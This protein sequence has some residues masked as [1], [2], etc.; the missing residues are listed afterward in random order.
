[1][2]NR[3]GIIFLGLVIAFMAILVGVLAKQMMSASE[4]N[5]APYN[6]PNEL[7]ERAPVGSVVS[8]EGIATAR[9]IKGVL[10]SLTL[11]APIFLHDTLLTGK[12]SAM[13]AMLIDD[14]TLAQGE[15]SEIMIEEYLFDPEST[16][17]NN[18]TLRVVT[19]VF[20][21]FTAKITDQNPEKFHVKTRMA[22]IGIRGC[23][24][25]FRVTDTDEDVYIFEI[26]DKDKIVIDADSKKKV[27]FP[28]VV[29]PN[30]ISS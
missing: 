23:E 6:T 13:K 28:S 19:G 25:G 22:T 5:Y 12:G 26:G 30:A 11:D 20:R 8:L 27:R 2:R 29:P 17:N 3:I 16:A 18:C 4:R 24:L 15:N 10:R 14:S 9:D 7:G 21:V 1:M